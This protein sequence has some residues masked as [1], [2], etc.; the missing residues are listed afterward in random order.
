MANITVIAS[1]GTV[2]Q[3]IV[4]MCAIPLGHAAINFIKNTA[5]P[6]LDPQ[7]APA[8]TSVSEIDLYPN[9]D[10]SWTARVIYQ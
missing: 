9:A 5:L 7:G 2:T 4:H 8:G 10:G 6:Q 1:G 3:P